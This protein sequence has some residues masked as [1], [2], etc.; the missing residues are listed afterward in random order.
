MI[1]MM[2]VMGEYS[3]NSS[4]YTIYSLY[5]QVF[6][7]KHH[8]SCHHH[9]HHHRRCYF[10]DN[11]TQEKNQERHPYYFFLLLVSVPHRHQQGFSILFFK[12]KYISL[13]TPSHT[14]KKGGKAQIIKQCRW[15]INTYAP[16]KPT[17]ETDSCVLLFPS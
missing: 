5:Y 16:K 9:H 6:L 7:K 14:R 3:S 2:M 13:C 8:F 1:V 15:H 4:C 10:I 11:G 12:E 17:K